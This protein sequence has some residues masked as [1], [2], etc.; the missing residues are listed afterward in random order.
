MQ[1]FL[2]R[3]SPAFWSIELEFY[4]V[5]IVIL[6]FI[7]IIILNQTLK[8]AER[9]KAFGKKEAPPNCNVENLCLAQKDQKS[10]AETSRGDKSSRGHGR[11]NYRGRGRK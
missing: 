11:R 1:K 10:H 8:I 4:P 5:I 7:T 2:V 6:F 3:E 9:E